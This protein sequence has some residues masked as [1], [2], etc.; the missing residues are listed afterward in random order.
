MSENCDYVEKTTKKKGNEYS[1]DIE[2][3]ARLAGKALMIG[4]EIARPGMA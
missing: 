2:R 3:L 1:A 4:S